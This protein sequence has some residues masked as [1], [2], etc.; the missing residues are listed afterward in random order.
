MLMASMQERRTTKMEGMAGM[1]PEQQADLVP[2]LGAQHLLHGLPRVVLKVL[3]PAR[4][5]QRARGRAAQP[6]GAP[7]RLLL[8]VLACACSQSADAARDNAQIVRLPI[9]PLHT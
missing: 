4:L 6:V 8:L 1:V 5:R 9:G 2:L 3:R 7:G